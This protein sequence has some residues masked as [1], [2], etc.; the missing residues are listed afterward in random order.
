MICGHIPSKVFTAAF[1]R[2]NFP[3]KPRIFFF[4]AALKVIFLTILIRAVISSGAPITIERDNDV[5]KVEISDPLEAHRQQMLVYT[6]QIMHDLVAYL[7][8]LK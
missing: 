2:R 7:V 8:T 5:P 3:I 6:D 1:R 4:A